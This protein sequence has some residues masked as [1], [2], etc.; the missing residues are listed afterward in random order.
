MFDHSL[1]R[2]EMREEVV[3][4]LRQYYGTCR[5]L[6]TISGICHHQTQ[7]KA[8]IRKC[9]GILQ[10]DDS[11]QPYR[12]CVPLHECTHALQ[13]QRQIASSCTQGN[14][15][16][17]LVLPL[18]KKT[19]SCLVDT[20]SPWSVPIRVSSLTGKEKYLFVLVNPQGGCPI[21]RD[22]GVRSG[23]STAILSSLAPRRIFKADG[24]TSVPHTTSIL[25]TFL[26]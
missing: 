17:A 15:S 5:A 22:P 21:S 9:I 20:T 25:S 16:A 18:L 3:T 14:R 11:K 7:F 19:F 13:R 4:F 8:W 26:N 2:R 10:C 6:A 1:R 24:E 12:Q 23:A